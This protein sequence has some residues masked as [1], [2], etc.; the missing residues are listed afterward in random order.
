M[1][2][3]V[4]FKG[5]QKGFQGVSLRGFRGFQFFLWEL[6]VCIKYLSL[7]EPAM[8][9]A[10]F[11]NEA[12][13]QLA[14][15]Y[16]TRKEQELK[17][18]VPHEERAQ[19]LQKIKMYI[20]DRNVYGIDLN[21]T[22]VELAEVS[23][24]LNTIYQ[25][26][27]VP[28]F[29]TQI[30][31]GNSLIGARRQCY[32]LDQLRAQKGSAVWYESAPER[33][34]PDKNRKFSRQAYHFLMGDP[35]MCAYTDKVIK[36]LEPDKIQ[37]IKD[38]NKKF[39]K[40]FNDDE[41]DRVLELSAAIDK[42]WDA[43]VDLRREIDE[44]TT[45]PLSV[46]GQPEDNEHKPLTIREKDKIYDELYL[47][48]GAENASPYARLKA[49]MDYWCALWFWPIEKAEE[50]PTRQE[51]L[52]DV[53]ML[54]GMDVISTR[55]NKKTGQIG[56]FDYGSVIDPYVQDMVE[57]YNQFGAVNLDRLRADFPR[58][59]IANEVAQQQHFFHWEL[60]FAD[61]FKD[62]GGFDLCIGN[63]P[64]IKIEWNEQAVLGDRNPL[65]A[66]KKYSATE[67]TKLRTDELK[68][69]VTYALYFSE[70]QTM[71]GEQAF[72][73]ATQNYSDIKGAINLFKC[74]LPQAWYYGGKEGVSAFVHPDGVYDDP[75]G[76]LLRSKLYPRLRKHFHFLNEL[77][78]FDGI[79]HHNAFSLNVYCNK[80]NATFE[81]IGN[82]FAV[83]T[84]D[85]CYD[86]SIK[87]AVPG[88]KDENG[89]CVKGHPDR[90]IRVGQKELKLFAKLFD[91]SEQWKEARLPVLHARQ[92]VE[93]LERFAEQEK[94]LGSLGDGIFTTEM[95]NETGA[96]KD[97]TIKRDVHFPESALDM[98]YS[99]PH[100]GVANPLFK[101]SRTVC[102]LNSDYDNLDLTNLPDDYLQR[103]NY[104]PACG[105][106]EYASR[107]PLRN[108][109]TRNAEKLRIVMRNMFNQSGERTL[110]SAIVPK[111]TGHVHAVF[112]I[113][114][115]DSSV[116]A[117][118]AGCMASIDFDFYI[119]ATGKGS[120]GIGTV[121][122]FPIFSDRRITDRS[123][124]LNSLSCHYAELWKECFR[125]D[126]TTDAWSK[127][128][129]RLRPTRFTTLT[130]EWTWDTPLR[131]DYE[132][133]QALV[134]I[135]VLTAMALG[136]TLDQLKT[137][138]RIQFPVLQ[139]YEADTWYDANGRIVFT[140]NRSLTGV[141][142]DRKRWESEM[143]DAP[144]GKTFT[145]TI[146]DDTLPGGPVERTITYVAPFD[147]CDREKDYETAWEFFS[148]KDG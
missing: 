44:K 51:F 139:Q 46:W 14:E 21:P 56:L 20:A 12:V 72:L 98:I 29:R 23:L 1:V 64:W 63:P 5:F 116:M 133:R 111:E 19:E 16:L 85:E 43:H 82:L 13:S 68:D 50:L 102:V 92:F 26:G 37:L 38:W 24:W 32:T 67:T 78:L 115:T 100:I 9:S 137:I 86:K 99:G 18:T 83:E 106:K 57:K 65:F 141:G 101:T 40:P 81:T 146:T 17:T 39:T 76:G 69:S 15:A 122:P 49:V 145:Q 31:N 45:D 88:I 80:P 59:R 6:C 123:L 132:R 129:P 114:L 75:K 84:L 104:S 124:L 11:L 110:V 107:E 74:F 60:E 89:W 73:G 119:R 109:G 54:L 35:G 144:A 71:S 113:G 33:I 52:F 22:A 34:D 120:G 79:D 112:E 62:R 4:S 136:M 138:Y 103:C 117:N 121:R 125:S 47:S 41:C 58:L 148:R 95:W 135:D 3:P 96:Q 53:Q 131:T 126:F 7:G 8:G 61:L 134:E 94:T 128:D 36:S 147:K 28:W 130:P 10:A 143:K 42:L 48:H 2:R 142:V 87:G 91:G 108:N 66:V 77:K 118:L 140:V 70:Y 127:S 30:V 25:G 93:V 55:V 97:G 105:I 90:V 27:Y